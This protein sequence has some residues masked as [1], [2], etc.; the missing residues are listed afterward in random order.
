MQLP[1]IH[2]QPENSANCPR[3]ADFKVWVI[4]ISV[5]AIEDESVRDGTGRRLI[6]RQTCRRNRQFRVL[7]NT[8]VAVESYEPVV[9]HGSIV[10]INRG[11]D[12][13]VKVRVDLSPGDLQ[14]W[15]RT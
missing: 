13:S 10:R 8:A 3:Q 11:D 14:P 6:L 4:I 2:V 9:L 15:S 5:A 12:N 1:G 7:S